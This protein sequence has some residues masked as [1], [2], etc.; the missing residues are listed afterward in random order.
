MQPVPRAEPPWRARLFNLPSSRAH[1]R[2]HSVIA[3]RPRA[4]SARRTPSP[5]RTVTKAGGTRP[6]SATSRHPPPPWRSHRGRSSRP[7][8]YRCPTASAATAGSTQKTRR[9]QTR[10]SSASA[11][12][13]A[14]A[15]SACYSRRR[16]PARATAARARCSR[17]CTQS[18]R[19]CRARCSRIRTAEMPPRLAF[20][21]ALVRFV[22]ALP[23]SAKET[24]AL[25]LATY[26]QLMQALT[27]ET[28]EGCVLGS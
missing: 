8:R 19:R 18:S 26:V 5:A 23:P 16:P 7:S 28:T 10:R 24:A 22:D 27:D 13:A 12:P 11:R 14:C 1:S 17:G 6:S 4:I 3:E 25:S 20:D 9:L 15:R 21:S 2:A